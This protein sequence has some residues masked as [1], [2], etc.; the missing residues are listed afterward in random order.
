MR[1][2]FNTTGM[3][4]KKNRQ[5]VQIAIWRKSPLPITHGFKSHHELAGYAKRRVTL[6]VNIKSQYLLYPRLDMP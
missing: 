2:G 6:P 3:A 4:W 1:T 5:Y